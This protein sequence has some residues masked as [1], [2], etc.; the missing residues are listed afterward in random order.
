MKDLRTGEFVT[1][2]RIV[3]HDGSVEFKTERV[4]KD[5]FDEMMDAGEQAELDEQADDG[6]RRLQVLRS[7]EPIAKAT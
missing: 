2:Q 5:R 4:G 1:Y 6:G 3:A 7:P